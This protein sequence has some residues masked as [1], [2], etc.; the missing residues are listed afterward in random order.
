MREKPDYFNTEPEKWYPNLTQTRLLLPDYITIA[1]Q[2][3]CN[4]S[5]SRPVLAFGAYCYC[6]YC[7]L[8]RTNRLL[9]PSDKCFSSKRPEE[10]RKKGQK[11][12][13]FLRFMANRLVSFGAR[14]TTSKEKINFLPLL[15]RACCTNSNYL[16]CV[17]FQQF[18]F[19][20]LVIPSSIYLPSCSKIC[21][22]IREITFTK[23]YVI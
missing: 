2:V 21:K 13:L 15:H 16:Q 8:S 18:L 22:K 10:E 17:F 7:L 14:K 23:K 20:I 6:F 19:C 3:C 11:R 4:K 12:L 1:S 9:R 5:C